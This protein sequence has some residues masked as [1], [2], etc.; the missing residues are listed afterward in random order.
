MQPSV[1]C[2]VSASRATLYTGLIS[3]GV[4]GDP[5]VAIG[6]WTVII[7]SRRVVSRLGLKRARD[8]Y[9]LQ[10]E[11]DSGALSRAD[12]HRKA[13]VAAYLLQEQ[14]AVSG[15]ASLGPP[16]A[17]VSDRNFHRLA[18]NL[19]PHVVLLP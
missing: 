19:S 2:P 10:H 17:D 5:S 6:A 8:F 18:L 11:A 9:L 1:H 7:H 16:P 13:P 4:P 15:P 14:H 3:M 12:P